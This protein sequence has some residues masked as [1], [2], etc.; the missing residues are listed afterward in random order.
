MNLQ[1]EN[2]LDRHFKQVVDQK[3]FDFDPAYWEGA[4]ALI[5]SNHKKRRRIIFWW[6]FSS[7]AV[8]STA[9]F[10][11]WSAAD[12]KNSNAVKEL[13]SAYVQSSDDPHKVESVTAQNTS[14]PDHH[15]NSSAPS[16]ILSR[17]PA[18]ST[19]AKA[20]P[21]YSS[22]PP[23]PTKNAQSGNNSRHP[24]QTAVFVEQNKSVVTSTLDKET[25]EYD[26]DLINPAS[27][28]FAIKTINDDHQ[29]KKVVRYSAVAIISRSSNIHSGLH[30]ASVLPAEK[31]QQ[32]LQHKADLPVAL[33]ASGITAA[34]HLEVL[35]APWDEQRYFAGFRAGLMAGYPLKKDWIIN[36]GIL[37]HQLHQFNLNT[38][39]KEQIIYDFGSQSQYFVMS[40]QTA[41]FIQMPL[42]LGR[43][44]KRHEIHGGYQ[45]DYL[46]GLQGKVQEVTLMP[47]AA[48]SRKVQQVLQEVQNGWLD[49]TPLRPLHHQVSVG[50]KYDLNAGLSSG[51]NVYY[52]VTNFLKTPPELDYREPGKLHAGIYLRLKF[53]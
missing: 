38:R 18:T 43:S 5:S 9:I 28:E 47:S 15:N 39:L 14:S 19:S 12:E 1:S 10:L 32:L 20:I 34:L 26:A 37:Y 7:M 45:L 13:S 22:N 17:P 4:K 16:Q 8:L 40:G 2:N 42:V 35:T 46:L 33:N 21:S 11:L 25:N 44:F 52:R 23:I 27:A 53:N 50:Y 6:F 31:I 30:G 48:R 49:M 51:I 3:N 36:T 29:I 41:H 24:L